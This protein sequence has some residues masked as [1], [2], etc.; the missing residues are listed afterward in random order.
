MRLSALKVEQFNNI[1]FNLM[2]IDIKWLKS[3]KIFNN[4]VAYQYLAIIGLKYEHNL[5]KVHFFVFLS[6]SYLF[7]PSFLDLL[8]TNISSVMILAVSLS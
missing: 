5:S 2:Q 6:N 1:N 8:E 4:F 3:I 7:A